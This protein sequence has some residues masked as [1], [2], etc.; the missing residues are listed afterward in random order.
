M[1]DEKIIKEINKDNP[2]PDD[3]LF[4]LPHEKFE[5]LPEVVCE[6]FGVSITSCKGSLQLLQKSPE[7]SLLSRM[8]SIPFCCPLE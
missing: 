1:A 5:F 8:L 2:D 6:Q 3:L 7:V 4:W